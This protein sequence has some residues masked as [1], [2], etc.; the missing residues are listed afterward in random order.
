[1]PRNVPEEVLDR[2][3]GKDKVSIPSTE[4]KK[5]GTPRKDRSIQ[6]KSFVKQGR[7]SGGPVNPRGGRYKS[8]TVREQLSSGVGTHPQ[9]GPTSRGRD[10]YNEMVV[11]KEKRRGFPDDQAYPRLAQETIGAIGRDNFYSMPFDQAAEI[12]GV[13]GKLS[14]DAASRYAMLPPNRKGSFWLRQAKELKRNPDEILAEVATGPVE[15]GSEMMPADEVKSVQEDI[16]KQMMEG[17]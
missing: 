11:K 12:L 2:I 17:D 5:D 4:K 10:I 13:K 14:P 15:I 6:K 7:K 1:M 3:L 9:E 8:E 16:L